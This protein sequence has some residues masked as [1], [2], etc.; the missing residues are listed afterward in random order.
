MLRAPDR[1]DQI[2]HE[3]R[4]VGWTEWGPA[5]GE[6][7]L[8]C[9]GAGTS[10]TLGFG[11]D[12]VDD[13]DVRLICVDRAGLGRS[14]PDPRKSLASHARD[15]GAVIAARGL[16]T[17]PCVA[18]SQGA[19]FGVAIAGAGLVRALAIVAGQDE[20]AH[21]RMRPLVVPDV[22]R[23]ID[24]IA[25]DR[26]AFEAD[27]AAKVDADG[28]WQLVI[29][30]SAPRDRAL[31]EEPA[32]AAAYRRALREGFAQG[33]AG[34]VRDLTL[35]L[36]PWSTPPEQID[37]PAH[38]W[39]GALDTSPVHSPDHGATLATRIPRAVRR[40]LPEEGG[41]LLW[42]RARDILADL[43]A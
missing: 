37:V 35:A 41:S 20:L 21:P 24:T 28:L 25:A 8:F 27:F 29:A 6:P 39:Y 32:F 22:L 2:E 23:L 33:P 5:D 11:G 9:S 3:G 26:D 38:L 17:P 12:V 4:T 14:S 19:P 18:V 36:S 7:V 10:S 34:Y 43:L 15:V 30:M 40:L 31:Y 13:L 1:V 42:T 16:G